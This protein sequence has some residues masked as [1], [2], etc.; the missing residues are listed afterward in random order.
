MKKLLATV[1]LCAIHIGKANAQAPIYKCP[2]D[3]NNLFEMTLDIFQVYDSSGNVQLH[4]DYGSAVPVHSD[5]NSGYF[6]LKDSPEK[7]TPYQIIII[8]HELYI[9]DSLVSASEPIDPKGINFGKSKLYRLKQDKIY[10]LN[11]RI[12][13]ET[14]KAIDLAT[15]STLQNLRLPIISLKIEDQLSLHPTPVTLNIKKWK[16]IKNPDG[17]YGFY[18]YAFYSEKKKTVLHELGKF[19]KLV[20]IKFSN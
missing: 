19:T 16:F 11:I 6:H 7:C 18:N 15:V 14:D 9:I 12:I 1:L 20:E 3:T 4:S 8:S 2:V 10:S 5:H 13:N 17:L